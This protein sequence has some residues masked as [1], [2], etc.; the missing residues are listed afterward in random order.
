MHPRLTYIIANPQ[1][2]TSVD[3][4]IVDHPIGDSNPVSYH[5]ANDTL[6]NQPTGGDSIL[7]H[8]MMHPQLV[9][10]IV[11]LHMK[12]SIDALTSN[13]T[14]MSM[15]SFDAL[16]FE[17]IGYSTLDAHLSSRILSLYLLP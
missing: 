13:T 11:N 16:P 10:P 8:L 12:T 14:R 4:P 2:N 3:T 1:M 15:P 7:N 17:L 6:V 9:D 5:L